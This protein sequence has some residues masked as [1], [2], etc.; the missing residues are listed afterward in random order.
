VRAL[1]R[2]EDGGQ[3]RVLVASVRPARRAAS[4]GISE[5][6]PI[7][8]QAHAGRAVLDVVARQLQLV[9]VLS[10]T[11]GGDRGGGQRRG[12]W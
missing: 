2:G 12:A 10:D 11:L 6:R 7:G 4:G 1:L 3:E 8:D 5:R 9:Q